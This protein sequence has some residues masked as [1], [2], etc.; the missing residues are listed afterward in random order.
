M[1]VTLRKILPECR[2]FFLDGR[3]DL[4]DMTARLFPWSI[5][6]IDYVGLDE[7]Q[8]RAV[9]K[10]LRERRGVFANRG[11]GIILCILNGKRSAQEKRGTTV[12][13]Q[14]DP[15]QPQTMLALA[16]G[17]HLLI[18]GVMVKAKFNGQPNE[19]TDQSPKSPA[20]ALRVA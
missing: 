19:A 8:I 11:G 10:M 15:P 2:E 12:V 20:L 17:E 14:H 4:D 3:S 13:G 18:E 6:T 5:Q 16:G 7:S 9:I 1:P